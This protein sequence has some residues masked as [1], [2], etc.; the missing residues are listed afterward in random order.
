MSSKYM[1]INRYSITD[2]AISLVKKIR[3]ESDKKSFYVSKEGDELIEFI[4]LESIDELSDVE[5]D[6]NNS[7]V[8]FSD[9]LRGDIKRELLKFVESPI[10]SNTSVPSTPNVQ[11]RHV[12]VLPSKYLPYLNWRNETIFNVVKDNK[13]TIDSFDA[14]HS[15]ISGVPGVMFISCFSLDESVYL[16]PFNDEKYKDIVSQAGNNYI[17]GGEEGLYTKVYKKLK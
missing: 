15:L 8:E 2:G 1:L 14:Y 13:G 9:Y 11:L 10:K 7:F 6:L 4:G 5:L 3:K 17:T 16:K 12:E